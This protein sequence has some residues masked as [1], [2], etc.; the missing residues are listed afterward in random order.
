MRLLEFSSDA[1]Y[2]IVL[3]YHYSKIPQM[4][5]MTRA[6]LQSLDIGC[7]MSSLSIDANCEPKVHPFEGKGFI[8]RTGKFLKS[9]K[10]EICPH[11]LD[12]GYMLR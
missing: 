5:Q 3:A 8:N 7:H 6:L 4:T 11:G 9:S 1:F 10:I 12:V 2:I